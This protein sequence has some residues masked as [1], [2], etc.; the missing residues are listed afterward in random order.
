MLEIQEEESFHGAY[1]NN[2]DVRWPIIGLRMKEQIHALVVELDLIFM[3][4]DI[5]VV[6]VDKYFVQSKLL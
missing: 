3:K 1:V 4:G 6:I 5:I 2:R